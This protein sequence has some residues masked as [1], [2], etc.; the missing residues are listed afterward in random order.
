MTYIHDYT[1]DEGQ[2]RAEVSGYF[3]NLMVNNKSK[4]C[5]ISGE[6]DCLT[7]GEL[8]NASGYTCKSIIGRRVLI[9][10]EDE[11]IE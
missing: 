4:T 8:I 3:A 1:E 7:I 11:D 9:T 2:F 6:A 10:I 5:L